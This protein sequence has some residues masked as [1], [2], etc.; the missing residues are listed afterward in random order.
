MAVMPGIVLISLTMMC[1][2]RSTKKSQR[3]NPLASMARRR[4]SR[5][6]GPDAVLLRDVGRD[7]EGHHAVGVLGLVVV[8][9][10]GRD[11]LAGTDARGSS[12][13][14]RRT[15]ARGRRRPPRRSPCD[16]SGRQLEGWP[17]LG[18]IMG[19]GHAHAGT[20]VGRLDEDGVVEA[21]LDRAD[22]VRP[23]TA[24]AAAGRGTPPEEDPAA[25]TA[26]MSSLSM[27]TELATTPDPAY[28]RPAHSSRP[29]IVPSSAKVPCRIGKATSTGGRTVGRPQTGTR[30]VGDEVRH[31]ARR[32]LEAVVQRRLEVARAQP[33]ALA[34]EADGDD[35]VLVR[36]E[37]AGDE[38]GRGEGDL[39]LGGASAEDER[40]SE[41]GRSL[42]ASQW[43][44]TRP[45]A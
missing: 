26:F 22:R 24:V 42:V 28:A 34:R 8:E 1:G 3:E 23:G 6:P 39:V 36:V 45:R 20:E 31:V 12:L 29:W 7:R 10:V 43:R 35:L 13:P 27:P 38:A 14:S 32:R 44:R 21:R 37:H 11:D 30:R 25:N 16:R 19:L 5:A 2:G 9:L 17:E 4:R 18:A 33:A 41:H 15:R 40:Q